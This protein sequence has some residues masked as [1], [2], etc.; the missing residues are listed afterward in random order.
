M[1]FSYKTA[2]AFNQVG[3]ALNQACEDSNI[4]VSKSVF[5]TVNQDEDVAIAVNTG[6]SSSLQQATGVVTFPS[7]RELKTIT[8]AAD[9]IHF[10]TNQ[11]IPAIE[12]CKSDQL[13]PN[14]WHDKKS[15]SQGQL[16]WK[17]KKMY[18]LASSS[19]FGAVQASQKIDSAWNSIG[20]KSG[21]FTDLESLCTN[22]DALRLVDDECEVG[23]K[24]KFLEFRNMRKIRD[25]DA[26]MR[27][28]DN[29]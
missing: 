13:P 21:K 16:R 9:M 19:R 29:H 15:R 8:M 23:M 24:R 10:W 27:K 22:K 3:V 2:N 25:K 18:D 17:F 12:R 28:H 26:K 6:D 20:C 7:S 1:P 4:H 14:S 11:V 5:V